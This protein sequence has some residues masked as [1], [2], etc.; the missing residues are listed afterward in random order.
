[1]W[2]VFDAFCDDEVTPADELCGTGGHPA[3]SVFYSFVF[4]LSSQSL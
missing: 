1:M 4:S 3:F 2:R